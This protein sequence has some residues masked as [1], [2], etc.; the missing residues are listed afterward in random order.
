MSDVVFK[1]RPVSIIGMAEGFTVGRQEPVALGIIDKTAVQ[2]REVAGL[3][4]H[5]FL[6]A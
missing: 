5:D 1:V 3:R 6:Q 2:L 4:L